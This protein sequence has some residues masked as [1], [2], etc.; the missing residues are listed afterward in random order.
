MQNVQLSE[1]SH[2]CLSEIYSSGLE[3]ALLSPSNE[4]VHSFV[5]CKDFFQDVI[6]GAIK[7]KKFSIYSLSYDPAKKP[8]PSF[9]RAKMILRLRNTNL[10]E[11][12]QSA[13]KALRTFEKVLDMRP[14]SVFAKVN[15]KD[16]TVFLSSPRQWLYH[17]SLTSLWCLLV[18]MFI[19]VDKNCN[20]M[21]VV[22]NTSNY[23]EVIQNDKNYLSECRHVLV[24][25]LD[26]KYTLDIANEQEYYTSDTES[27]KTVNGMH[28][29]GLVYHCRN[30]LLPLSKKE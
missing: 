9:K 11:T 13:V 3:M 8:K 5:Y 17:P 12:M 14:I 27:P 15:S 28:A 25:I 6:W 16:D 1:P 19:Y 22:Q 24:D 23:S 18:R 30:N 29:R 21:D 20:V 10:T 7:K 26:G 2:D 4:P